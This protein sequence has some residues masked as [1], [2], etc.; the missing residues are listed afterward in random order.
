MTIFY[1]LLRVFTFTDIVKHNWQ[2][3][4][5][6]LWKSLLRVQIHDMYK[7]LKLN[8]ALLTQSARMYAFSIDLRMC[9]NEKILLEHIGR[10][11]KIRIFKY[12]Q[13]NDKKNVD[14]FP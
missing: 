7:S 14:H 13:R 11:R 9:R 10:Y 12:L 1:F 6:D 8:R 2:I 5:W 3:L 4:R